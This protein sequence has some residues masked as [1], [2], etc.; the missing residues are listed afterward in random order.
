M[1]S[2]NII[3]KYKEDGV[4]HTYNRGVEKR[5]VFCDESDCK[6]FLYLLK[7]YLLLEGDQ[8]PNPDTQL[9]RGLFNERIE[10]LAYALMPNHF[11][12]L[13]KQKGKMDISEFMRAVM[14]S[15]VSYFNKKNER[16]GPLF[17]G[18][19][20]AILIENDEYLIHLSK[21]IHLNPQI[22]KRTDLFQKGPSFSEYTSVEDYLGRRN[23]KW[24]N[25]NYVL[26]MLQGGGLIGKK[27]N[28]SYQDFLDDTD[29]DSVELLGKLTLE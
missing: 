10:I 2:K 17:Q 11:H 8:K 23:A 1:P 16:T 6:F 25:A 4:Y 3:K 21:Y 5:N 20:K 27:K 19:Y 13:I 9:K 26:D 28:I 24:V 14:T 7:S 29:L 22:S 18:R 12:L 15:Y